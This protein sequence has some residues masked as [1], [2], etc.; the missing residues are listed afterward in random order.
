MRV[1]LET[2][3]ECRRWFEVKG[4]DSFNPPETVTLALRSRI[5]RGENEISIKTH[6]RVFKFYGIKYDHNSR[7]PVYREELSDE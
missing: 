2:A 1:M 3:C 5:C 7:Y 6:K 4:E